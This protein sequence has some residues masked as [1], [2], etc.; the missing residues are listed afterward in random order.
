MKQ[1]LKVVKI[2]G[3][4]IENE[5]LLNSFLDDFIKLEGP[6]IL[7]HGG[8]NKATEIAGKLGLKSIP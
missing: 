2:G 7:C 8:G 5:A 3:K 6:K 4:L 1:T